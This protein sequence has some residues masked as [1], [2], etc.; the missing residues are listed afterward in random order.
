VEGFG[1]ASPPHALLFLVIFAGKSGKYHQKG[2]ILVG[3]AALQTSLRGDWVTHVLD[4]WHKNKDGTA[5]RCPT[6]VFVPHNQ[7]L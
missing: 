7:A 2:M 1:E 6:L 3:L 5:S 4:G